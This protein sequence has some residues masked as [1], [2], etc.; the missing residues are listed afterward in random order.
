MSSNPVRSSCAHAHSCS[1]DVRLRAMANSPLLG[2][3]TPEQH[4]ELDTRLTA[5]AWNEGDPIV[6]AGEMVEGSYLIVAGRARVTRDTVDGKE[7][8]V[9]IAAPGDVIGPISTVTAPAPDSVW[10]MET[11]CA[12]YLPADALA[13]VVREYPQFA[14]SMLEMQHED[15]SHSRTRKV[16]QS[17]KTVEQRVAGVILHLDEKLGQVRPDGSHLIQVRIRRDDIAGMAGTTIE[18][19]SR[20]MTKMKR[21]GLI[22]SGRE[23]VVVLDFDALADLAEGAGA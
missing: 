10:A 9:D 5:W 4:R 19:A 6:L 21:N 16:A 17:T 20:A 11:T 18:S 15:L 8:T 22:D 12:L 13:D 3:L 7:I 1:H 23:W 14:L 2:G